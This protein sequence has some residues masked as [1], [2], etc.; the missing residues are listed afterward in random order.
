MFGS[1]SRIFTLR[2]ETKLW[3]LTSVVLVVASAGIAESTDTNFIT[4]TVHIDK[5]RETIHTLSRHTTLCSRIRTGQQTAGVHHAVWRLGRTHTTVT[6][7]LVGRTGVRLAGWILGVARIAVFVCFAGVG[8]TRISDT[9]AIQAV[10]TSLTG[11]T[12]A[13]LD[14]LAIGGATVFTLSTGLAIAGVGTALASVADL[15]LGGTLWILVRTTGIHTDVV[16]VV[17]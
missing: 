4:R 10:F 12:S 7:G 13:R 11:H 16:P 1:T 6:T 14:A 5:A 9:S 8:R 15:T 2:L 3:V 17:C